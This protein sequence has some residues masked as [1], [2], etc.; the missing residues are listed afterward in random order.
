MNLQCVE[1][2]FYFLHPQWWTETLIELDFTGVP[3]KVTIECIFNLELR[4]YLQELMS[5]QPG[6]FSLSF[7]DTVWTDLFLFISIHLKDIQ[8][9]SKPIKTTDQRYRYLFYIWNIPIWI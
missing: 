6:E 2:V 9:Y 8:I 4:V 3:D 1:N 7:S 5:D